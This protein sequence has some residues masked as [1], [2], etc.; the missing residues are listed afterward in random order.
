VP[1]S[2][3]TAVSLNDLADEIL[4]LIFSFTPS[5]DRFGQLKRQQR[6]S[7]AGYSLAFPFCLLRRRQKSQIR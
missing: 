3:S 1:R 2:D 4:T 7:W 5:P 6:G